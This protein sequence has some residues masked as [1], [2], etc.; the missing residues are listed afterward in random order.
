[1]N[2]C[3]SV[4]VNECVTGSVA[5]LQA[6]VINLRAKIDALTKSGCNN[7]KSMGDLKS[8]PYRSPQ[9]QPLTPTRHSVFSGDKE[10]IVTHRNTY[11]KIDNN[12][13]LIQINRELE[14]L[15]EGKETL[16]IEKDK[17]IMILKEALEKYQYEIETIR[18]MDEGR[19]GHAKILMS[20]L[21]G[22]KRENEYL[23]IEVR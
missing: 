23:E 17:E 19:F 13:E 4:R 20:T 21:D 15:L 18:E 14:D 2:I 12:A 6:E 9:R 3:N 7:R 5:A 10:N 22:L 8:P 11:E 16:V 1:M